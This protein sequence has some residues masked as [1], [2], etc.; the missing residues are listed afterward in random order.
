MYAIEIRAP[1]GPE[2]LA[3]CKRPRPQPKAGEVLI[4]VQ[5]AGVN[6]PDI[7]QRLGHYPAPAGASDIPGL[8]VA[9]SIV[10]AKD[11]SFKLGDSVCALVQ[12]G[13][14]AEFCTAP[15]ELCLPIPKGLSMVEAASLPET[16]FTVWSNVFDRAHLGL[17]SDGLKETLL[18]HGASS[19]IGVTAVQMATAL[20]HAVYGTAGDDRKCQAVQ[21]FGA[22]LCFN[23][24]NQDF[25]AEVLAVTDGRGVDVILDMVGG[26]Y[27]PRN[28]ACLADEGR[29]A[30]IALLG[31]TKGELDMAQVLRRRLTITGSTLRPRDIP[32]KAAIAQ[33]LK[34]HIWP[35]LDSHQIK[36]VIY[37]TFP[38]QEAAQAHRLMESSQHIGKIVLTIDK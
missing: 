12:A 25:V 11:T 9:G 21:S 17:R 7:L 33:K 26:H 14:Y 19:G 37:A 3:L 32:F 29:I 22:K 18:V 31:G 8:E 36:P 15:A 16:F 6:R 38:L 20:G 2:V 24:K 1:G 4:Q 35:L 5:A 13:G 27:L 23:Y 10:D 30:L 28:L 34:T